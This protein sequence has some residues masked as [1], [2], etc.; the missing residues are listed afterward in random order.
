MALVTL[1]ITNFEEILCHVKRVKYEAITNAKFSLLIKERTQ[2]NIIITLMRPYRQTFINWLQSRRRFINHFVN[3]SCG[4]KGLIV[5]A[6]VCR[7]LYR[8]Y[9]FL[10][11]HSNLN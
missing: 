3:C 10:T 7:V 1:G 6:L 5:E 8:V 4:C 9:N 2:S 11:Y